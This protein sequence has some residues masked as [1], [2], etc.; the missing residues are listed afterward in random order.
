[1]YI[2]GRNKKFFKAKKKNCN[3][4]LIYSLK[5]LFFLFIVLIIFIKIEIAQEIKTKISN[6]FPEHSYK[7]LSCF[8]GIANAENIYARDLIEYYINIG[9]EKFYLGDNNLKNSEKLIDVL[10]DY[11]DNGTVEIIDL[12]GKPKYNNFQTDF[13][14]YVYNKHKSKC[15]WMM[16]FDFD[17][18]LYFKDNN[19]NATTYLSNEK[20]KKC[21]II[22]IN[23]LIYDDNDLLYYEN[24]KIYERFIRPNYE[25]DS[26]IF[27]KS[28]VKGNIFGP[29]WTIN[30]S[31]HIPNTRKKLC[32]SIGEKIKNNKVIIRPPIFQES[33]IKH[34]RYKSAEE[35]ALK[36]IRGYPYKSNYNDF[37]KSFFTHNKFSKEKLEIFERILNVTFPE[38]HNKSNINDYKDFNFI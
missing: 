37:I 28:I 33:Y 24:K 32:N 17:E 7:Y 36:A 6:L 11:V 16:F 18:F 29:I 23:W 31:P 22:K 4:K 19:T 21:E 20:F 30:G 15:N 5:L 14:G 2:V 26:N 1:M 34:F 8:C 35:Y 3:K 13:Y 12:I 27:V 38:Y 9:V 10:Y 25:D